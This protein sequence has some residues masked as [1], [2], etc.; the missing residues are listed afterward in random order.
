MATMRT[1][2]ELEDVAAFEVAEDLLIRRLSTWAADRGRKIDAFA[3]SAALNF[4]HASVDGRL[5]FWTAALVR[6]FLLTHAPRALSIDARDAAVLP[7]SLRL[8][9]DY[10]HETGLADPGSDPRSDIDAA[11]TES[12]PEFASA[13]ADPRNFGLAKFWAMTAMANGV[14]ASDAGA[15]ND[16]IEQVQ[17]GR[18]EY[19]PEVLTDI[20]TRHTIDEGGG[21]QRAVAQ[22][23]VVLLD[24]AEL[25]LAAERSP[26]VI[27]LRTLVEWVG[28]GRA[29]T[30]TGNLRLADART[31]VRILDT[32][33]EID[34]VVGD[35][36]FRTKSSTD[37]PGLVRL[38]E[39]AKRIR[40]LR[41]V[42]GRLIRVAKAAPLLRDAP[43]L[44]TAAF[45]VW[46]E[47][48]L[49]SATHGWAFAHTRMLDEILDE[50]LPDLLNTLYGLPAPMPVVH[51]TEGAW[52]ACTEIFV[53]DDPRTNEQLREGV[54]A[55]VRRLLDEL[56]ELGAVSITRG[57]PEPMFHADLEQADDAP[58]LPPES[59]ARLRAAVTPGVD[60][61]ELVALT[62][63]ATRAVMAGLRRDGRYA[64][65]VGELAD[66]APAQLL[67][68]VAEHYSAETAE[69]EI[70]S[71]LAAHG[72]SSAGTE[73]LL[74]GV[75]D[76]PFRSRASA[77]LEV[78]AETVPDRST[79]LHGLRGDC[80]IGPLAV[81]L[82]LAAEEITHAD[83]T[84]E[85]GVRGM[86]E[87]FIQVLEVHGPEAA[88]G[89]LAELPAGQT[90]EIAAALRE[91]GHPDQVGLSELDA[92]LTP[93]RGL[94]RH[95]S[96]VGRGGGTRERR[97]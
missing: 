29:L 25:A 56:A 95:R 18:V 3:V 97:R 23:P 39:S 85:E 7:D 14:D 75:R 32:G 4:R 72:G 46:P 22:L 93:R 21:Q 17:A 94:P 86:A 15:M 78:L 55:D 87:Q 41:V 90:R 35:R 60:S 5:A 31:L 40:V 68:M 69:V 49:L 19:D 38:L 74:D 1:W 83:L 79:F 27:Q 33:D 20:T 2:Y 88:A 53:L 92:V 6:E 52:A 61:V 54:I 73:L 62:P 77:M 96:R 26:I 28:D 13:M 89:S 59:L 65:L 9:I 42:K 11:I 24:E 82:L 63:L 45:D 70:A 43:A 81:Q 67:G 51:L 58:L 47:L 8:L 10:L 16:F 57:R 80:R 84:D 91:S 76:C 36:V 64:P 50:L 48:D 30:A 44:W 37:L 34:P 71:W 66:A 12:L